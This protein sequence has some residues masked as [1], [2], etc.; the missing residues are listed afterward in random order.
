[1]TKPLP[2]LWLLAAV[3][4]AAQES[5]PVFRG[6][7]SLVRVDVH[8]A[9][10][11]RNSAPLDPQDFLLTDNGQPQ[12]VRHLTREEVPLDLILLFDI[13]GS[14]KPGIKRV[15]S[16]ARAALAELR[17]D[18]RVAVFAFSDQLLLLLPFSSDLDLVR[19]TIE[20]GLLQL[21]FAGSTPLRHS[22]HAAAQSFPRHAAVQRRRALLAI[23]DNRGHESGAPLEQIIDNLWHLDVVVSG[24]ALGMPGGPS[25]V[26]PI[27]VTRAAREYAHK[28]KY[29]AS[30]D[31]IATATGGEMLYTSRPDKEFRNLINRLRYRYSLYYPMPAA[32]PGE[33]RKITI[34][35]TRQ[36]R[37]QL[38]RAKL[39]A[40]TGYRVP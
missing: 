31:E 14:M 33:R 12:T 29:G 1:M 9:G 20:E 40:R 35:L 39:R 18:D 23:T 38:G 26:F 6:G 3:S 36:A 32:E 2:A 8:I 4:L 21:N 16:G 13:S 28:A 17:P 27:G 34:D 15:A 5:P 30:M 11:P 25:R 37:R 19:H 10:Q 22:I 24:L 7:V